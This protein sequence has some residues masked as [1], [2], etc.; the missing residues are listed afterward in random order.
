LPF[1]RDIPKEKGWID[2]AKKGKSLSWK[3]NKNTLKRNAHGATSTGD[4]L[5]ARFSYP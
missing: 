2:L 4:K 3:N 5:F 1:R